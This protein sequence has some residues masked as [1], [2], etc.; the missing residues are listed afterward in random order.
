MKDYQ[1]LLK[2]IIGLGLIAGVIVVI[3]LFFFTGDS[4]ELRID[5][6][7]IHIESIK[8]IAEI[9]TVSY[10]DEIVVDSVEYYTGETNYL[11]PFE[12][13]EMY[14]RAFNRNV[15]KRLTL[16]FKG[17]VVYGLDLIDNNY[18]ITQ[19]QDTLLVSLPKPKITEVII[20]PTATEVFQEQGNWSDGARKALEEK[21]KSKLKKNAYNLK[22]EQKAK[23]NAELLIQKLVTSEKKVIVAFE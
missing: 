11:D 8:T 19:N 9:A 4:D 5:E 20:T 1:R 15:K 23:E 12:W 17:E 7:P 21:A 6:T 13:P 2:N 22:L 18:R 3:Y 16:I 14:D 10:K